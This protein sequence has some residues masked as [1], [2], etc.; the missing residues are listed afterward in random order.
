MTWLRAPRISLRTKKPT[1]ALMS[2]A[3]HQTWEYLNSH[4][5]PSLL[6]H[7][8][9]LL[10]SSR[11]VNSYLSWLL[12]PPFSEIYT[13]R[14]YVFPSI[15]RTS[16]SNRHDHRKRDHSKMALMFAMFCSCSMRTAVQLLFSIPKACNFST[17]V[18]S[19]PSSRET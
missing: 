14:I 4:R 16:R 13:D 10:T 6:L 8:H 3:K 11:K 15:V 5:P 7:P 17:Y 2:K 12:L 9:R 1:Y 19:L 18:F